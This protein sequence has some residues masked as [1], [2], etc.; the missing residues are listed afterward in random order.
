MLTIYLNFWKSYDV[1]ETGNS[2]DGKIE[3]YNKYLQA[4]D[5]LLKIN[6]QIFRENYDLV[7]LYLNEE[8]S[9]CADSISIFKRDVEIMKYNKEELEKNMDVLFQRA[10]LC[11]KKYGFVIHEYRALASIFT[12]EDFSVYDDCTILI[13]EKETK[14]RSNVKIFN[15][16]QIFPNPSDS[17]FNVNSTE[18]KIIRIELYNVNGIKQFELQSLSNNYYLDTNQLKRGLYFIKLTMEDLS[19]RIFKVAIQ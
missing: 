5:D 16:I 18:I 2:S 13:E 19:E 8:M 14:G 7:N 4:K 17:G 15:Q 9:E 10:Q 1:T 3:L 12:D 11:S 6:D